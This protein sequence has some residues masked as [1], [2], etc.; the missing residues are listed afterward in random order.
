MVYALA[1]GG[2]LVYALA[3]AIGRARHAVHAGMRCKAQGAC[4][5]GMGCMHG[6]YKRY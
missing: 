5:A 1:R 2:R 6:V 4:G 3:R